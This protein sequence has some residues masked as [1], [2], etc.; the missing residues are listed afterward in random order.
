MPYLLFMSYQI[1][2]TLISLPLRN[3]Y[4]EFSQFHLASHVKARQ[5]LIEQ[6]VTWL[7][8]ES[9][10]A[11]SKRSAICVSFA[12]AS[13]FSNSA[14]PAVNAVQQQCNWDSQCHFDCWVPSDQL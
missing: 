8:T 12:E 2:W 11:R 14:A 7:A 3:V 9:G 4:V 6:S 5:S 13:L 10:W 1:M